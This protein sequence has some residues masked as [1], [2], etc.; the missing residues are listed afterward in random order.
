MVVTICPIRFASWRLWNMISPPDNVI[1][2]Q[3]RYIIFCYSPRPPAVW[4][5][6]KLPWRPVELE[7]PLLNNS[8]KTW[9]QQHLRHNGWFYNEEWH[10]F[11]IQVTVGCSKSSIHNRWEGLRAALLKRS[12]QEGLSSLALHGLFMRNQYYQA[13]TYYHLYL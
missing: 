6:R 9:Q 12:L 3:T 7:L 8:L 10:L 13:C 4:T 11:Y 5:A 1:H 2:L